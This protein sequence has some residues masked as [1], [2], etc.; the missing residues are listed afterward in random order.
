MIF[1]KITKN[2]LAIILDKIKTNHNIKIIDIQDIKEFKKRNQ[3]GFSIETSKS[4]TKF[5]T[6]YDA[7]TSE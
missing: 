7:L 3:Y 2:K 6:K 5:Y 1:D 4:S